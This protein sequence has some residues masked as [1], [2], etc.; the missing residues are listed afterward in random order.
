MADT[1]VM[2]ARQ[3]AELDYAFERNGWTPAEVKQLSSGQ[4][5]ADFR[6]VLLGNAVITA[7][8]HLI[9][10]D[11]NPF[12]PDGWKVEEH[13][14]GGQFKWN[15]SVSLHLSDSQ[16]KGKWIK[17][18]ELRKELKGKPVYNANVLDY[19][20][21]NPHLIPEEWKGKY[22]FFWGTIYRSSGG[23]LCVR[24]LCWHVGMWH[25]GHHWLGDR[26]H[27]IHPAAVP[28]S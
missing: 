5:L 15:T 25:C 28:A 13:Q 3:A 23:S 20:L 9:N 19:L 1:F 11:A 10:L 8:D 21:A 7:H 4:L 26:W 18:E 27:G 12:T 17:G 6:Q 22:V 24:Y 14:K 2:S 16:K